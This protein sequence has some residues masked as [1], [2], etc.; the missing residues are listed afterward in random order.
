MIGRA[1]CSYK[2]NICSKHFCLFLV[3]I[4]KDFLN[5]MN[6]LEKQSK[7]RLHL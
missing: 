6:L 7:L 4:S 1:S 5:K 3:T 2:N